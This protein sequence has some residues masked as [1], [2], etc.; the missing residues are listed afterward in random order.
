MRKSINTLFSK[1]T[2]TLTSNMSSVIVY[3]VKKNIYIFLNEDLLFMF[4]WPWE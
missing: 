1:A 3:I 2:E 4:Q